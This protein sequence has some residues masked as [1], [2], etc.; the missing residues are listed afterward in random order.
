MTEQFGRRVALCCNQT[1]AFFV[2]LRSAIGVPPFSKKKS[3]T[4]RVVAPVMARTE[5]KRENCPHIASG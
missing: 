2:P 5:M 1:L 3:K 4:L